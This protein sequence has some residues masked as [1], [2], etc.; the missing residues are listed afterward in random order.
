MRGSVV[1]Q[2][3]TITFGLLKGLGIANTDKIKRI[4][5]TRPPTGLNVGLLWRAQ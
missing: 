4:D 1:P 5:D 3:V 2:L